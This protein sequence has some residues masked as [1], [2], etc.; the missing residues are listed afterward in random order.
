MT[1]PI[2]PDAALDGSRGLDTTETLQALVAEARSSRKERTALLRRVEVAEEQ[3]TVAG[4]GGRPVVAVTGGVDY[5]RPNPRI[6]PRAERWDDSWD[7]GLSLTWSLWDGGRVRAELTQADRLASAA[8]RRLEEFDER[9]ALEV[10]QRQLEISS[11]DAAVA[12]ADDAIRA[13]REARRVVNERY[14]AGVATELEVLDADFTLL[15]VELDRTRALAN[16]RLAEAQLA[17]A[18]GR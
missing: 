18:L 16:L 7:A 11:H 6:F 17:R 14:L 9:L 12:A 10:R 8:R 3:R 13:A 15:Q 5:A 1:R 2:E 4:A